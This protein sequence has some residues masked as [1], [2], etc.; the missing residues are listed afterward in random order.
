MLLLVMIFLKQSYA[1]VLDSLLD[2][3]PKIPPFMIGWMGKY[4]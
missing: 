4:T 2:S 3:L 1:L